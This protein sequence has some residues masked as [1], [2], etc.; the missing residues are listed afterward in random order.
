MKAQNNIKPI[1]I[2]LK[3]LHQEHKAKQMWTFWLRVRPYPNSKNIKKKKKIQVRAE[4][5]LHISC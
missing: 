4:F 3:L 2:N 5:K 1:I